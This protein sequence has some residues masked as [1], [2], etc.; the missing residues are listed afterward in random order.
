V[1][2]SAPRPAIAVGRITGLVLAGGRGSRMGAVDKGLEAFR[3]EPL[4]THALERMRPQVGRL[5][6]SANRHRERYEAFGHPVVADAIAG[7]I[8]PLA[9]LHAGLTACT[10]DFLVAVPCDAPFVPRDLVVRLSRS[11][12]D[13]STA[14]AMART[15]DRAHPVFCMMRSDVVVS[16]SAF[17]DSGRRSVGA[18]IAAM[19]GREVSFDDERSFRNLNTRAELRDAEHDG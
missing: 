15:A 3:G 14:I 10:T 9:G 8:G 1:T 16:L 7:D 2:G 18:W 4:V 12:A 19:H 11:F 6:L 13:A 5:M 17:I